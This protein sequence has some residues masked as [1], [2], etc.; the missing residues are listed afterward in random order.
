M[1]GN[2]IDGYRNSKRMAINGMVKRLC[3]EDLEVF[4]SFL[5]KYCPKRQ[6]FLYEG[7]FTVHIIVMYTSIQQP[8][9][10]F[11]DI[12]LCQQLYGETSLLHHA[13][14]IHAWTGNV[15]YNRHLNAN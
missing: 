4:H 15:K 11:T 1:F 7:V 14:R 5:L 2:R 6:H 3:K 10:L 8:T 13:V 9:F 12:I